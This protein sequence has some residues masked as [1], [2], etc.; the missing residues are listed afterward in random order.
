MNWYLDVLRKYAVFEGRARRKEYWMFCLFNIIASC[1]FLTLDVMTGM[2]NRAVGMGVFSALYSL[3]V[4]V[5][6]LAVSVR[7]LHDTDRSGWWL[8]IGLVPCLG[9]IVLIVYAVQGGTPGQ[10]RFGSDPKAAA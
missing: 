2:F 8:L 1:A 6:S 3:A 9:A 5:P 10:N 4:I 7:R